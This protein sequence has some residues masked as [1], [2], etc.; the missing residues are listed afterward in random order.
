MLLIPG[1]LL[2]LITVHLGLVFKQKHTQW[3]GPMRT[4]PNVVGERMF[5]RYALKQGGF[6]MAV[7]G[8]VALMAG[9]FQINPIWL[10]GPY[11]ASEVS[12]ASQPDW[13]V[14]FMDGLVRLMPAW[15]ITIPIGDG[16]SIP[17]LFWP[18]VVGSRR[19]DHGA[20]VL[21]VHRGAAAQ[22]Q[23]RRTTCSSGPGTHPSGSASAR[24]RSRSSSSPRCPAAT[25][26]SPT[27]STS[28]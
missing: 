17:P 2:A 21:S 19:A 16:Y 20:D 1:G 12:S 9:L 8:V 27:S 4:N 3:P 7:F 10:F 6:F 15:Q 26:S 14:M 13:Y 22:G 24:W 11:R 5:P 18:A 28:A 25:T 23:G